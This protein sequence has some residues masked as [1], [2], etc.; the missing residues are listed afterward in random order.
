[1]STSSLA[2]ELGDGT[3][4]FLIERAIDEARARQIDSIDSAPKSA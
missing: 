1:L 3:L 4:G 2:D